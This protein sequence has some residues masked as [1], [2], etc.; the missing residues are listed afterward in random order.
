M[1]EANFASFFC[2]EFLSTGFTAEIKVH[3][4]HERRIVML[5]NGE[6]ME[7]Q[8]DITV[9]E[10]IQSL[11]LN[12]ERIVVEVDMEIIARDKYA[13]RKLTSN[14]KVEIIRFVGGG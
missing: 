10:L 12:P 6:I 2:F 11:N 1:R 7:I 5:V 8:S 3:T 9:A 13:T 4:K 14:S